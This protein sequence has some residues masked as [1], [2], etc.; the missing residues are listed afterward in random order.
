MIEQT[1][2]LRNAVDKGKVMQLATLN[3][4]TPWLCHVWYVV[5]WAENRL[6]FTSNTIRNHSRHI[7][8]DNR[9]AGAILSQELASLGQRVLGVTFTGLASIVPDSKLDSSLNLFLARWPTDALVASKIRSEA[10]PNRLYEVRVRLW[11]LHDEVNFP[12][13]PRFELKVSD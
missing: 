9:V 4:G 12:D 5:D 8:H 6:L 7:A 3:E 11:V 1:E 10:I 13:R 2:S